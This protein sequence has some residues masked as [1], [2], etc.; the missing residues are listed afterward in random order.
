MVVFDLDFTLWDCGGVWCD[1][2]NPPY[3]K[4]NGHIIDSS[5]RIISLYPDVKD[6]LKELHKKGFEMA[7]ASRTSEPGWA[8]ELLELFEISDYF[9]MQEIYPSS[10]TRHFNRLYQKT[11]I[12]FEKMYFLDDEYRNIEE[13]SG[14]GVNCLHVKNGVSRNE[15]F[16]FLRL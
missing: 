1:C 14:L 5:D 3:Y 16:H 4:M 2:T 13:V 10:K 12:P 15:V 8:K 11:G 9:R 7:L 6:I